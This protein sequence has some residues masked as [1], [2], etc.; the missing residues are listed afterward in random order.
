[1]KT[2]RLFVAFT[3]GCFA[4]APMVQA[5]SGCGPLS[6]PGMGSNTALGC[7]ALEKARAEEP[8]PFGNTAVGEKAMR[9]TTSG[10]ENT[11]VGVGALFGN[12]T[13]ANNTA[14]GG[15]ALESTN[16]ENN[17]ATGYR[18]M[19]RNETGN[20]NVADGM[21]ALENHVSGDFN[22]ATGYIAMKTNTSGDSNVAVGANALS[23]MTSGEENIAVGTG[24]GSYLLQGNLNIYVGSGG[25]E[26][27][28]RES[29]T[30]R[31]GDPQEH[32]RTFIAGIRGKATGFGNG[33][34]VL[35]DSAGQLGTVSSSQRFKHDVKSMDKTSEAVFGLKPVT[36]QYNND[37][38]KTPQ[39]GLIAEEVV[40]VNPDLV[41]RDENGEIYT[42]RY[43]AVNAMLLN[44]FL[45][46]HKKV[47]QQQTV[48]SQLE[49]TVA[50]QEATAT[51]QQ[52][53]IEVLTAGL[54][55]VSTQLE[56]SK[57][58]PQT[59]LNNNQ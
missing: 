47:E 22:T 7:K 58:A 26:T 43:D 3:L 46:E 12:V 51:R 14:I 17:T 24:A 8:P 2:F 49:S 10:H 13:G 55:K 4:L 15:R 44:E 5:Q 20:S 41:V 56:L 11:A 1:M 30:I 35:V 16:A 21:N 50:K 37:K 28:S 53:E 54:Q 45:K 18:A 40:K 32:K 34:P 36:F 6:F 9:Q 52:K 29:E 38:S 59:V 57:A 25:F 27:E 19:N 48:I 31:I 42:V 23:N 39:F 33:I